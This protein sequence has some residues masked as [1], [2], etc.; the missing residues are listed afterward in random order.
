MELWTRIRARILWHRGPLA[1]LA[2]AL[3]ALILVGSLG[4]GDG[5]R[6]PVVVTSSDLPAGHLITAA[7]LREVRLQADAAPSGALPR[8][9][10]AVGRT[11]AA[12]LLPNSILQ[13]GM[14]VDEGGATPGRA[15]VPVRIPD[16]A[17]VGLLGPGTRLK[18][19]TI[20]DSGPHVLTGDALVA[21]LPATAPA[22]GPLAVGA[23][24][25]LVLLDVP[26]QNALDVAVL[27]QRGE[28]FVI[29]GG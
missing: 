27:G 26:E 9:E 10:D 8:A 28:L 25:R 2:A 29:L 3:G 1:A 21:P 7:D 15:R 22:V 19:V 16:S 18:L 11:T 13:P 6:V 12:D 24:D 5:A 20:G 14:L 23:S 4:G 17:L